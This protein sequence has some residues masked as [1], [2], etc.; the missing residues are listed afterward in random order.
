MSVCRA[1]LRA[2]RVASSITE[3]WLD[4]LRR[5]A[6]SLSFGF[7]VCI[8]NAIVATWLEAEVEPSITSCLA[9]GYE[10]DSETINKCSF[11]PDLD[12]QAFLTLTLEV[13]DMARKVVLVN[14]KE[15]T[16]AEIRPI[17]DLIARHIARELIKRANDDE[18]ASVRTEAEHEEYSVNENSRPREAVKS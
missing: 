6:T 5:T 13:I 10:S 4:L 8:M 9:D 15:F 11:L 1:S 3:R 17:L 18:E 7:F 16:L 12:R 14:D 2:D